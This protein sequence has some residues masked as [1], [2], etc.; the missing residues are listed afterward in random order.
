MSS[1]NRGSKRIDQDVYFTPEK[2]TRNFLDNFPMDLNNKSI[3]EPSA[4]NGS[5]CK[6][7]KEKY[8]DAYIFAN[9]IREEE[10]ESLGKYSD[11]IY[12]NDFLTMTKG[13]NYDLII[14][15]P[16]F[17]LASEFLEQ[18]FQISG[19]NTVIAML[20]RLSFL[21]SKRRY[22]FWQKNPVSDLYIL[23][24]RPSF[25]NGKTDSCAYCW[26]VWQKNSTKQTIQII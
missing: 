6:V 5:I 9:E 22:N 17:S 2:T 10:N 8:P 20:L 18:C 25:I 19:E 11:V 24:E 26:F 16:P 1:T 12:N 13:Y 3:L 21:E 23:S 4:G 14:G 7:I 15:N